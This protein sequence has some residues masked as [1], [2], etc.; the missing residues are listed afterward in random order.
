MISNHSLGQGNK[1]EPVI[2]KHPLLFTH[3]KVNGKW[4]PTYIDGMGM[5][6]KLIEALL[7]RQREERAW[8]IN[9]GE[10]VA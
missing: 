9:D 4:C 7:K 1:P 3:H 5:S 8:L 2:E 10:I 6:P